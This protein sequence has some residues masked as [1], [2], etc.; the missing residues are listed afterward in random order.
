V[1]STTTNTET[2]ST[3]DIEIVLRRVTADLVMI[4]SSTRGWTEERACEIAHDVELLARKGY[5][6][7][8]DVTLLS[9]GVEK[10]ATRFEVNTSAG[11]LSMSRPGGVMW[12]SVQDPELRLILE[13][14]DDYTAIAREMLAEKLKCQWTP[15]SAD[16]THSSL[17]SSAGRDYASNGY[18]IQ[19][20]DFTK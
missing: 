11:T 6:K 18:G 16:T 19:R 9:G 4:A 2:Y 1:S 13:Y 3:T 12:P 15:T 20:K 5:M 14:T 7:W 17:T 10:M 8:V